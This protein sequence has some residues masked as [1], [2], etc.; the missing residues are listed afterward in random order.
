MRIHIHEKSRSVSKEVAVVSPHNGVSSSP[1]ERKTFKIDVDGQM[2]KVSAEPVGPAS[3]SS[4]N[5]SQADELKASK[6]GIS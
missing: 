5:D 2:L 1:Q 3:F 4:L 6:C